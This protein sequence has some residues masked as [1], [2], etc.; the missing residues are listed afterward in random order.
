MKNQKSEYNKDLNHLPLPLLMKNT[1]ASNNL[2]LNQNPNFLIKTPATTR[3]EV[4]RD[5]VVASKDTKIELKALNN[6]QK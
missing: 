1:V 4:F 2:F 5:E 3:S 6:D